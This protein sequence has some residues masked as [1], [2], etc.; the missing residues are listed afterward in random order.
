M[1]TYDVILIG[2]GHNALICAA[3]LLKAGYSVLLLE[4]NSVPGGVATTEEIMP[5]Q[6][7]GFHFDTT[8]LTLQRPLK[9]GRR[10]PIGKIPPSAWERWGEFM[11]RCSLKIV[12]PTGVAA[13]PTDFD[14]L[15]PRILE[16]LLVDP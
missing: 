10:S 13:H 6:A 9:S 11:S 5:E 16:E 3:Y 14:R 12:A 7:P 15:V 8:P 2:A 4:K 1:Q